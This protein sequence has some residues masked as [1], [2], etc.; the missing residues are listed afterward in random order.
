MSATRRRNQKTQTSGFMLPGDTS[1]TAVAKRLAAI[2]KGTKGAA[3]G[4][5]DPRKLANCTAAEWQRWERGQ[6]L[7]PRRHAWFIA[8]Q[9]CEFYCP[10]SYPVEWIYSGRWTER[11]IPTPLPKLGNDLSGFAARVR[12]AREAHGV[13]L[14]DIKK[15][16]GNGSIYFDHWRSF[17][18]G[19]DEP[20]LRQLEQLILR[21]E[22]D[23]SWLYGAGKRAVTKRAASVGWPYWFKPQLEEHGG[24]NYSRNLAKR[25]A[26]A[27]ESAGYSTAD[28][29]RIVGDSP[30]NDLGKITAVA[31]LCG[32][33]LESL[34]CDETELMIQRRRVERFKLRLGPRPNNRR[35]S[36][37]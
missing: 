30:Q 23:V 35:A 36:A 24:V 28:I 5:D 8:V 33:R 12:E 34:T 13:T 29:R 7:I 17:E 2:R 19:L 21:L 32:V 26:S 6:E 10:F 27:A 31:I 11:T 22:V 1:T 14:A 15:I 3:F 9:S 4:M 16:S 25:I 20:N 18:A 37:A